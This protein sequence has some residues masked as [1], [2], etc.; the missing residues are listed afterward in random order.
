[1]LGQSCKLW[2][3]QIWAVHKQEGTAVYVM[4]SLLTMFPGLFQVE[5]IRSLPMPP[6]SPKC[7]VQVSAAPLPILLPA[8]AW[9]KQQNTAQ[10]IVSA[11][12]WEKLLASGLS[13]APAAIWGKYT[14]GWK[15]S[16]LLCLFRCLQ[17]F[18]INKSLKKFQARWPMQILYWFLHAQTWAN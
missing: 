10:V 7:T 5:R 18:Q 2:H 1:M 15:S 6:A 14:S 3:V 13:L 11:P 12:T 8:D 17:L 9:G 16:P 4:I